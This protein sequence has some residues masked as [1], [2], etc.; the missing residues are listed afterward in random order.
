MLKQIKI[1]LIRIILNK[2]KEIVIKLI[3]K[4]KIM[5]FYKNKLE[6]EKQ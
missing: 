6:K 4:M 3:K 2:K 1:N 5:I